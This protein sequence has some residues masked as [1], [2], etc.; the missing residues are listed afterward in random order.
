MN[1]KILISITI[2]IVIL[3]I[4]IGVYIYI[5][6]Q[7]EKEEDRVAIT[8]KDNLTVEFGSKIK[9]SD[10]IEEIKGTLIEDKVIEA[11]KLGTMNISFEYKSIRNKN[12][13]KSFDINVVDTTKP[14][15]YLDESLTVKVGYKEDIVDLI[16]SGDNEDANPERKIIGDYD[17]N[18]VGKY[19]LK[20][21]IKD[22]SGNEESQD[23][24]LNVVNSTNNSNTS[25]RKI[26]FQDAVNKYK[27]EN[28]KLGID[29]SQWQGNIDWNKV[30]EAGAEFAIIRL[31]YQKGYDK[32]NAIDP[33]FIKNI[34]GAKNAG[35][36]VGLYFY[37]YAKTKKEAEEQAN[38][39]ANNLKNYKIELPIA[40]DWESWSS[41]VK[42]NMSFYD[43]NSIAHTY[44]NILESKEYKASLYGSKNYLERVW[45]TDEFE[46]IWLAHYTDNTNYNKKYYLWQMCNTGKIDGID[47]DVDIDILYK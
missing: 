46:N 11:N 29:V 33:Y 31:G 25:Q 30:K 35:L 5:D 37:S 2:V 24:V 14:M 27:N 1:K 36:D 15:I 12:K 3:S 17:I 22:K 10:L 4:I 42:C 9:V 43:I 26:L 38:F 45:Y 40:F 20:Y 21:Y 6:I 8:L 23:F 16:F 47:G 34:E 39:I 44:I 28:N 13:S 19:N 41:F 32:E 7:K 18:K